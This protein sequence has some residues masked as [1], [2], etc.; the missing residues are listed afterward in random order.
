MMSAERRKALIAKA[1]EQ[2]EIKKAIREEKLLL[3]SKP[4]YTLPPDPRLKSLPKEEAVKVI[5]QH[6]ENLAKS[7]SVREEGLKEPVAK[8]PVVK[9]GRPKKV[10]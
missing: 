9:R 7:I 2:E 8:E 5:Q 4:V 10:E 6:N 3:A 1:K